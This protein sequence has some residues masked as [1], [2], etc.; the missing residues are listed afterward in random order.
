MKRNL[1]ITKVLI[2]V[3]ALTLSSCTSWRYQH[4]RVSVD[5]EKTINIATTPNSLAEI[6]STPSDKVIETGKMEQ[7]TSTVSLVSS[8]KS[9]NIALDQ[10]ADQKTP[11]MT[12]SKTPIKHLVDQFKKHTDATHQVKHVEKSAASG[13]VRIMIIL[14]VVGFILLLIGIFLSVFV[15]GAFWWLFYALGGLLLLAG[16]IVLIL[17]LLGLI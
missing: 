7:T 1:T 8:K 2:G 16:L 15:S 5:R 9:N 3:I 14:L 10:K 11:L 4:S 6:A 12:K 17:G 13:W